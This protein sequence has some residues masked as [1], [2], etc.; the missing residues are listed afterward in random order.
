[1]SDCYCYIQELQKQIKKLSQRLECETDK[2]R[3]LY[4]GGGKHAKSKR[5]DP[6][7]G[8]Q[9]GKKGGKKK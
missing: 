5:R 8:F 6:L 1:M 7:R 2:R 9:G 3:K 4:G